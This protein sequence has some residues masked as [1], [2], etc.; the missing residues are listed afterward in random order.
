MTEK[1][2]VENCSGA[3]YSSGV[4]EGA[5]TYCCNI[6]KQ[7]MKNGSVLEFG[8]A[9]GVMTKILY[10]DYCGDYTVV[11]GV[12]KFI[13]NLQEQFPNIKGYVSLFEDFVP[14]N[15]KKYDNIILGH[16][17]EHVEN[18]VKVLKYCT[19]LLSE[20]GKILSAV[21]N[22]H[23]LH[24]QAAVRM[25]LLSNENQLNPTDIK[26]G[27]RRVYDYNLLKSH[28]NEAG[29]KIIK[30]GGYWLKT[31][32]NS[33]INEFYTSKMNEAFFALGEEFPDIAAEIYIIGTKL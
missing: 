9:E 20:G 18:P 2:R 6:F 14:P 12:E 16:V 28:F 17:L 11:D 30:S 26:N 24:R 7:E 1:E 23:S 3:G 4:M 32:S 31:L 10:P 5:I 27:H 19:Q 8:P 25:G 15:G 13:F 33:Q 22:S 29:V 21:P